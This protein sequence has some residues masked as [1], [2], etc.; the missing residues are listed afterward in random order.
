[1]TETRK[2]ERFRRLRAIAKQRERKY[3]LVN[4]MGMSFCAWCFTFQK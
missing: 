1:M 2:P 4:R 3:I